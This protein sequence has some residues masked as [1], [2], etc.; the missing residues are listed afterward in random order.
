MKL[1]YLCMLII[2]NACSVVGKDNKLA[3]YS[4]KLWRF[5]KNIPQDSDPYASGFRAGCN[6]GFGVIGYGALGLHEVRRYGFGQAYDY[7][8]AKNDA[9]YKKGYDGGFN[10]CGTSANAVIGF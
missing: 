10:Y 9:D 4:P 1:F 2:L 6:D 3:W 7:D 5:S 8:R